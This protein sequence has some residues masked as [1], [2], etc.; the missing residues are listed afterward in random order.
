MD[1]AKPDCAP[2]V[3]SDEARLAERHSQ[4]GQMVSGSYREI[5]RLTG[6]LVLSSTGFMLMQIMDAVFL[7]WKSKPAIAAIG[8]ASM[9]GFMTICLFVGMVG[10]TSTFVAQY[11]GSRQPARVGV[12]VWQG[13]YLALATG[14][15]VAMAATFIAEPLFRW[16][17]HVPEVREL[18]V[19]YYKIICWGAPASLVSAAL[20]SFF[21]GRGDNKPLMAVQLAGLVLNG[22]LCYGLIFGVW[23]LPAG[24]VRSSAMLARQL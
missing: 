5:L 19:A 8:S 11:V 16:V 17:N 18:E 21:S 3:S 9:A 22:F 15:L 13:L 2:V 12:A 7:A 23:G 24:R 14:A 1:N 6:P 10:Y 4:R 20:S